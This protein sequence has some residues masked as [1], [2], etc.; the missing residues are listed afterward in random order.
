MASR[1]FWRF[2]EDARSK[3]ISRPYVIGDERPEFLAVGLAG[4][5]E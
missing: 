1:Q 4:E 5:Y 3:L 2:H